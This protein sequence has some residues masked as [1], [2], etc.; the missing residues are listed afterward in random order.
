MMRCDNRSIEA[1]TG[2]T[3]D[4]TTGGCYV[5]DFPPAYYHTWPVY[6]QPTIWPTVIERSPIVINWPA[7]VTPSPDSDAIQAGD[8][9]ARKL[10]ALGEDERRRVL[11]YLLDKHADVFA[12]E[13]K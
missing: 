1:Y 5:G 11:D 9:L 10:R 12:E 8:E 2:G 6:P 3:T 4:V 13:T 7:V